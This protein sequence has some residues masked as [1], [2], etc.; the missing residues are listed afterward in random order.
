MLEA[1]KPVHLGSRA[2][3]LLVALIKRSGEFVSNRELMARVW[4]DLTVEEG[5]LRVHIA[6]LRKA[7]K[8]GKAGQRYVV[9]APGRGY[10]FVA[11]V[12]AFDTPTSL[13]EAAGKSFDLPVSYVRVLGRSDFVEKI[14]AELPQRRLVSIVGPGGIGKTTVALDVGKTLRT[15]YRDSVR[16]VDLSPLSDPELVPSALAAE[17]GLGVLSSEPLPNLIAFLRDREMLLVLDTCEHVIET[18]AVLAE[19]IFDAAANVHILATSREP[20]R[21]RGEQVHRLSPLRVPSAT[22]KITAVDALNFSAVQLFVESAY[23]SGEGFQLTDDSAPLVADIC[24]QLDGI[25]LA[26]ELAAGLVNTFG[27]RELATRLNDRF[28]LLTH[29]R[30]TALA[31][32]RTLSAMLDWSYKLLSEPE[33]II[34]RRLAVFAGGFTLEAAQIL[35]GDSQF[36]SADV[37]DCIANLVAKSLVVADVGEAVVHYRLLDTT[38]AYGLSKLREAGE[39]DS[40]ARRHAQYFRDLFERAEREQETRPTTEWLNT[41]GR[42]IDNVRIALEWA[43]TGG[44]AALGISLTIAAVPLWMLLSLVEECRS[45]AQQAITSLEPG[46]RTSEA[47]KLFVA[48][49]SALRYDTG[50]GAD[51]EA[52]WTS[53]LEIAEHIDDTDYQLRALCGLWNVRL[54]EGNFRRALSLARQFRDVAT[55][56]T[57]HQDVL[58]G[59]RLI[60]F[61]LHYLGQHADAQ[62]HIENVLSRPV[63]SAHR[64][65]II[66]FGY[67]QRS[68]A[69]DTLAEVLWIQG[70]A[71]RAMDVARSTVAKA[72]SFDH[73]LSLCIALSQC[74]CPLALYAGDLETAEQYVTLLLE[75]STKHALPLWHAVGRCS[76]AVLYIKRGDVRA[77]VVALRGSLDELATFHLAFRQL[78]FIVELA[79]ALS[80]SG[81]TKK[82]QATIA[83]AL[84]LCERNEELW[85]LPELLRVKGEIILRAAPEDSAAAETQFMQSIDWA[86]RQGALSWELRAAISLARLRRGQGRSADAFDQLSAVYERFTEGFDTA[87]LRAARQL[88][89]GLRQTTSGPR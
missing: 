25:P 22:A 76:E 27:V 86:R 62:R 54:S 44:D 28:R 57:D 6:A 39:Y 45:R 19:A 73:E 58:V 40:I 48:L 78:G 63:S 47:M 72:Q 8:D 1:D 46:A 11:P 67:D 82:A 56:A 60:G 52:A 2:F 4:P 14:V 84:E 43:F 13:P 38:R 69:Y 49:G 32:H 83:E 7:L 66:R 29:G 31:R 53:A 81:E 23:E 68:R 80:L 89:D 18:A 37:D 3:H 88:L 30:R 61:T 75:H 50:A 42:Q 36:V 12:A 24:R 9:N 26:I 20:L 87:D 59:D 16:F 17:L 5:A 21:A 71:E 74:A 79:D 55:T 34:L 35:L 70:F 10:S 15:K 51:V 65:H 33:R 41:Y 64:L 77:G 85:Y